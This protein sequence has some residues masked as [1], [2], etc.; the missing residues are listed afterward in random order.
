[1]YLTLFVAQNEIMSYSVYS[2]YIIWVD[3]Y[4]SSW[5]ITSLPASPPPPTP[6]L[7]TLLPPPHSAAETAKGGIEIRGRG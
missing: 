7:L 5:N 2:P 6:S 3:V 4:I 1:M